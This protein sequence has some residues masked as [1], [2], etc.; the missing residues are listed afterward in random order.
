M[1]FCFLDIQSNLQF[2]YTCNANIG[3]ANRLITVRFYKLCIATTSPFPGRLA[4]F[5]FKYFR[6]Y[7][8]FYQIVRKASLLNLSTNRYVAHFNNYITRQTMGL[9]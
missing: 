4:D 3:N 5:R 7:I 9:R 1:N 8:F 6:I 2:L